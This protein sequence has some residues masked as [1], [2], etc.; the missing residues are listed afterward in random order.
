MTAP[1]Y[2]LVATVTAGDCMTTTMLFAAGVP[3]QPVGIGR[4]AAWPVAAEGVA[5]VHLY[6]AFDGQNL[7]AAAALPGAQVTLAGRPLGADWT[8][9]PVPSELRFGAASI[10]VTRKVTSRAPPA[11]QSWGG[12]RTVHDG[13]ALFAAAQKAMADAVISAV[14]QAPAPPAYGSS[15]PPAAAPPMAAPQPMYPAVAAPAPTATA[16]PAPAPTAAQPMPLAAPPA[17]SSAVLSFWKTASPVKKITLLLLPVVLVM[18]ALALKQED[19][20]TDLEAA[21]AAQAVRLRAAKAAAAASATA[22]LA[23]SAA[24]NVPAAPKQ[25][26]AAATVDGA[27]PT[28]ALVDPDDDDAEAEPAPFADAGAKAAKV[29][30]ADRAEKSREKREAKTKRTPERLALDAVAA[31]SYADA[32]K[33]YDA[34]SASHPLDPTYREAARILRDRLRVG[35]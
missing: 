34:L 29:S 33:M 35:E 3:G 26:E 32:A 6:V 1:E 18:T 21:Q 24:A 5:P 7:F 20:R 22:A 14:P 8:H 23:A 17:G 27:A 9:V 10:T 11:A 31:G 13:G 2:E 30:K 28:Q 16:A 19:D 4:Q 15:P 12:E 25:A